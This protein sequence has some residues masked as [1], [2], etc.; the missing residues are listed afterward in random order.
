[1]TKDSGKVYYGSNLLYLLLK[2]ITMQTYEEYSE[3]L[4]ST[5]GDIRVKKTF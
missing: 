5:I 4:L 3:V 1:M 2:K